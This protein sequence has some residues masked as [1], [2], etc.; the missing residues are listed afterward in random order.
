LDK[1][2]ASTLAEPTRADLS[3]QAHLKLVAESGAGLWL[4][5]PPTK[6][7]GHSVE[8]ELY[9]TSLQRRLRVPIFPEEHFCPLCDGVVDRFGDHCLVCP[10]GGDRTKRHN[11]IRN[12]VCHRCSAA[13]LAPELE[14]PGLLR[15]RPHVGTAE[16]DGVH[17]EGIQGPE[18]RRPADIYLP[19]WRRGTPAALDFAVTSGLRTDFLAATARDG[20]AA[21]VAYEGTKCEHLNTQ[22][23]CNSEGLTFIPMVVDA[24]GGSWGPQARKVWTELA[25]TTALASGELES[26]VAVQLLQSVSVTLHRE[27]ARAIRRRTPDVPE[28]PPVV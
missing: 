4:H 20:G 6:A 27:N 1:Q 26:T 2:V 17:R 5:T 3:H 23:H 13:G 19:R 12:V 28:P 25:K 18:G 10:G 22:D 21:V 14:K 15:P 24:H 16:E 9:I 11:L 7:T 8:P